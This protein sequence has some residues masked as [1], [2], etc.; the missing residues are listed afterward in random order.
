VVLPR[1]ILLLPPL[2]LMIL[3]LTAVPAP[4][5][6]LPAFS[7]AAL[8]HGSTKGGDLTNSGAAV[9]SALKLFR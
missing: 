7:A 1:L 6:L 2:L 8:A 4:A 3:L 5:L 9:Q